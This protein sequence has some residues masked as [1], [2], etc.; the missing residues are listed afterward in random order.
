MSPL[1]LG[2]ASAVRQGSG[3]YDNAALGKQLPDDALTKGTVGLIRRWW[4]GKFRFRGS[5]SDGGSF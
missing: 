5:L 3:K 1:P 4:P 2:K